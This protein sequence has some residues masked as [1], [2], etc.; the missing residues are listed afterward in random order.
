MSKGKKRL[1]KLGA[2]YL[3]LAMSPISQRWEYVEVSAT[4]DETWAPMVEMGRFGWE[5]YLP[6][7]YRRKSNWLLPQWLT[8]T[9]SVHVQVP[10]SD[11]KLPTPTE[12]LIEEMHRIS[13]IEESTE[14]NLGALEG[15]LR[16]AGK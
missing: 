13:E 16:D 5:P 14:R 8:F 15:L 11:W 3:L 6:G 7:I 10:R 12:R 9:D 4:N 2:L 1:L